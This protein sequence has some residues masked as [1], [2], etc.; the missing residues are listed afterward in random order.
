MKTFRSLIIPASVLAMFLGLAAT[1]TKAQSLRANEFAGKFSLPFMAQWGN[2]TLPP[3]DYNLYY[4][5]MHASG[6]RM[7]E[8]AHEDLGIL[9]GLVLTMGRDGA[10]GEGSFLVCVIEGNKAY[11]RSLQLAALG[12]SI[13][14][15]RPHGASVA[16]WIVAGK[17][18]HDTRAKIA[19]TRIPIAPVK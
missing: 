1:G 19:E 16:A 4:G 14:F 10:K 5:S 18:S 2:L 17:K 7:V 11:V 12:E 8:V 13:G 9:H 6:V 15:A 3:G